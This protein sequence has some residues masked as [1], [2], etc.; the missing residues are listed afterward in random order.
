MGAVIRLSLDG[1][2]PPA[3]EVEDIGGALEVEALPAGLERDDQDRAALFLLEALYRPAARS[4]LHVTG[5][6]Q[7][8]EPP[9]ALR[10]AAGAAL[11]ARVLGK[12]QRLVTG[13]GE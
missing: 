11:L 1:G 4:H 10:D 13:G 12:H 9:Q 6:E 7:R 8:G 3:V 5:V 2:V